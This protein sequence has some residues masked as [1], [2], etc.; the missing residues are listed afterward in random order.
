MRMF[1]REQRARFVMFLG[2]A[3]TAS[4]VL[5]YRELHDALG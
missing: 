2:A 1:D 4:S 3:V 5:L